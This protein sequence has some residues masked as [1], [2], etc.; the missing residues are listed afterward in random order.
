M[1]GSIAISSKLQ[2]LSIEL[3]KELLISH[4]ALQ[5]QPFWQGVSGWVEIIKLRILR[6]YLLEVNIYFLY[7][8]GQCPI[9][10]NTLSRQFRGIPLLVTEYGCLRAKIFLALISQKII[11]AL[12]KQTLV[13]R[14]QNSN[15]NQMFPGNTHGK[16]LS[17]AW[18]PLENGIGSWRL[19]SWIPLW[20]LFFASPI[21]RIECERNAA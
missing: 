2:W 13:W 17:V 5:K 7:Y 19:F 9:D 12:F 20:S 3:D 10:K 18:A 21:F 1:S 11:V 4:T 6:V 14:Y 15:L 8:I 16:G